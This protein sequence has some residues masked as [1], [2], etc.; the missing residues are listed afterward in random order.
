[1]GGGI[2]KGAPEIVGAGG[3]NGTLGIP[4]GLPSGPIATPGG[5]TLLHSQDPVPGPVEFQWPH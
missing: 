5:G 1:M 3:T 2:L 4:M